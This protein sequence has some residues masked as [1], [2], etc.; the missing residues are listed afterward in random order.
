MSR[1][2]DI[3]KRLRVL[4]MQRR[5]LD[6]EAEALR[7]EIAALDAAKDPTTRR[8][9]TREPWL[10]QWRK[11]H[12]KHK[13]ALKAGEAGDHVAMG[14]ACTL[15]DRKYALFLECQR[16]IIKEAFAP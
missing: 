8:K 13:A 6:G 7:K 16:A 14:D 3:N 1:R 4:N 11:L 12:R 9:P 2:Q 10:S 5:I 15:A